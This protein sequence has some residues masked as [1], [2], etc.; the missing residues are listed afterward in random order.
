MNT[1]IVLASGKSTRMGGAVDKCFLSLG[2]RPVVAWS[3]LAFEACPDINNIILA[4]RKEQVTAAW[5]IQKMF[6]LNKLKKIVVGGSRRQ[7]SV[8]AALKNILPAEARYVVIHDAARPC[9]TPEMVSEILKQAKRFGSAVVASPMVDTVKTAGKD[10]MTSGTLDRST[11]WAVQTPQA[12]LTEKLRAAYEQFAS[13]KKTLFTDDSAVLEAAG[14]PS[15]LVRWDAPNPKITTP[16]DLTLA[17]A[18]LRL[19]A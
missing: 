1:A 17:A 15:K 10:M 6:G 11:L 5:G 2:S 14:E 4:V 13:D 7:D 12:F 3:L 18:L 8:L 19:N 9:I 16:T